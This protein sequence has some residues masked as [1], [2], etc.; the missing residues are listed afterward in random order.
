MKK[1]PVPDS[2]SMNLPEKGAPGAFWKYRKDRHHCGI[3]IY[4]PAGSKVISIERGKVIESGVFTSPDLISYWNT[5]YY[6]L[7]E[8]LS[9]LVSKY[10]EMGKIVVKDGEMIEAGQL[11]GYIGEVLNSNKVTSESPMYIREL[12]KNGHRSM[13]HFELYQGYPTAKDEYLGGNSF[14]GVKPSNLLDPIGYLTDA[15]QPR[16]HADGA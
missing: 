13:L 2:Y 16:L 9:G 8:H 6:V 4:A 10:A 12:K 1:W 11:V 5:T 3:D 14:N 15:A 7:V